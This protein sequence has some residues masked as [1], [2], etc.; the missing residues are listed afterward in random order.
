LKAPSLCICV[1]KTLPLHPNYIASGWCKTLLPEEAG[2]WRALGLVKESLR[3]YII[4]A[5]GGTIIAPTDWPEHGRTV[6]GGLI[7]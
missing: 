4:N 7:T 1:P 2:V 5:Q 3:V 6:E